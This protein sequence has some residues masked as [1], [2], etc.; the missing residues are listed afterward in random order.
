MNMYG[1]DF[2]NVPSWKQYFSS[3]QASRALVQIAVTN[4]ECANVMHAVHGN[5]YSNLLTIF[6]HLFYS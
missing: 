4:G 2:E 6:S 3:A 5:E 1:V